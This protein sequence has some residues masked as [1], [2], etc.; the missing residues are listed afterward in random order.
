MRKTIFI[1]G[2]LLVT[3]VC[4]TPRLDHKKL[5]DQIAHELGQKGLEV[6]DVSCPASASLTKGAKFECTG[7]DSN[8]TAATFDVTATGDA[9]GTVTWELRGRYENMEVVGDKLEEGLSKRTGMPV[10]V[11]CPRKNIIIKKGVT[12]GCDATVG[13]PGATKIMKY[14]FTAQSDTGDWD[15]KLSS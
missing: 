4:C 14:T 7:K 9:A 1:S 12:F 3:I 11:T 6:A 2:V 10:D 13:N 8:G 5:E 15:V